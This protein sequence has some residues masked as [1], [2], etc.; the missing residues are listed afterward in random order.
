V[1]DEGFAEHPKKTRIMRRG[2]RQEVTGV[3]VNEKPAVPREE[4]RELR[5]LLHNALR[6]GLDAQNRA[7]HPRFVEHLVGRVAY[8]SMVDPV[9]GAKLKM[10]LDRVLGR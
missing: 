6:Q 1:T 8:V 9:R 10:Q 3:V 7:H 5:A 2:S 4:V